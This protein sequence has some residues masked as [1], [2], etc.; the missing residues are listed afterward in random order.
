MLLSD[1][2]SNDR[3]LLRVAHIQQVNLLSL[4]SLTPVT[5]RGAV[6]RLARLTFDTFKVLQVRHSRMLEARFASCNNL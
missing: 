4:L 6:M 5:V 3:L 2:V 1:V